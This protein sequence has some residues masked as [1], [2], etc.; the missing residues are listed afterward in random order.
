[1]TTKAEQ[2]KQDLATK[3]TNAVQEQKPRTPT[4]LVGDYL[5]KMMPSIQAVLPKHV[6]A[7]RMS[8]IALNVIRTNPKLL[9]C[10][11][12]SLMGAVMECQ[13]RLEP[14]LWGKRY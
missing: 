4:Q 7:E 1:M 5:E 11:I 12:N 2:L 6:T 13:I 14:D 9:Q 10:D 3:A 8:R